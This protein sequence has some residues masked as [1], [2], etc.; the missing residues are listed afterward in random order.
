[1][2]D[3]STIIYDQKPQFM[4]VRSDNLIEFEREAGFALQVLQA[5]SF[6]A[7]IAASNQ[8]SL[9]NAINNVRD[10]VRG[11]FVAGAR[12]GAGG[13]V[14]AEDALQ[15]GWM[16]LA[17]GTAGQNTTIGVVITDA[18]LTPGQDNIWLSPNVVRPKIL[19]GPKP[20][21]FQHYLAQP[22]PDA[23]DQLL[24]YDDPT[25][26]RG[27][28]LYWARGAKPGY[29]E[30]RMVPDRQT[31]K[32][33][34]AVD[35]YPKQYT[36]IRPLKPGNQF[37]FRLRFDNLTSEELGALWY[38]IQLGTKD[39]LRLRLGMGKPL[40]LGAI[41]FSQ[42]KTKICKRPDRYK[43]L[44]N[45]AGDESLLWAD[46]MQDAQDELDGHLAAQGIQP[47]R[48]GLAGALDKASALVN[49]NLRIY[50]NILDND[51][52]FDFDT[53]FSH[54]DPFSDTEKRINLSSMM[55]RFKKGSMQFEVGDV[56]VNATEMGTPVP[57]ATGA[58]T[59]G[60]HGGATGA[61]GHLWLPTRPQRLATRL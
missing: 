19:S 58:T 59:A 61:R 40:G 16:G 17:S 10:P 3:L 45:H 37:T 60:A 43:T 9:A 53:N 14:D 47:L 30:D 50:K 8:S 41:R 57:L 49:G 11:A 5:N 20:T 44:F 34:R 38:V 52:Q 26:V 29:I 18:Q 21:T 55:I 24:D 6:L 4:A 35:K 31:G 32:Q 12:D 25:I 48:E 1:M 13:F 2:N 28:K 42:V 46:G 51:I 15:A 54:I 22:Q 33:V 7:K 39:T 27:H 36:R 56:S 23:K